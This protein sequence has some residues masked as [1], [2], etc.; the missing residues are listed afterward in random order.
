M[1]SSP[2]FSILHLGPNKEIRYQ[3]K[4]NELLLT[5]IKGGEKTLNSENLSKAS[6]K[7]AKVTCKVKQVAE[8][9]WFEMNAKSPPQ[10]NH[11]REKE[12][13]VHQRYPPNV[14]QNQTRTVRCMK[15]I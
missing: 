14:N 2:D 1:M 8:Q 3:A 6:L 5:L 9:G 13:S 4:L 11:R 15:K 7:T 10:G 12:H